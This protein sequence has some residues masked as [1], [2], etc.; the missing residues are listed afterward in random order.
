MTGLTMPVLGPVSWIDLVVLAWF[1]LAVPSA[2]P[3][4]GIRVLVFSSVAPAP[5]ARPAIAA[6]GGEN[7]AGSRLSVSVGQEVPGHRG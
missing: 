5:I 2:V 1:A 6:C 4:G 3:D 7:V